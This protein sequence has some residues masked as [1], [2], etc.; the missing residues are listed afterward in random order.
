MNGQIHTEEKLKL[1]HCF[2]GM[3]QHTTCNPHIQ[4]GTVRQHVSEG[5]H[6]DAVPTSKTYVNKEQPL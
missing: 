2:R 1:R 4:Q 3:C 5:K 6:D